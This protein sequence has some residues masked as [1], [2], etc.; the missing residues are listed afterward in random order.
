MSDSNEHIR[1]Q[2][3]KVVQSFIP[4]ISSFAV[5]TLLPYLLMG[6]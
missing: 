5:K 2:A 4:K 3:K 1:E 6:L